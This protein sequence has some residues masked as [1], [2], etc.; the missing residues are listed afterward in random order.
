VIDE[1][2]E[3]LRLRRQ[4]IE[5]V[6]LRTIAIAIGVVAVASIVAA[7][8]PGSETSDGTQVVESTRAGSGAYAID[9]ACS[10]G[11]LGLV[12]RWPRPRTLA[13]VG[14]AF[15]ATCVVAFIASFSAPQRG[16]HE[17]YTTVYHH[18]A[19]RVADDL[20]AGVLVAWLV[21]PIVAFAYGTICL[22]IDDHV[23]R[24]LPPA[25]EFPVARVHDHGNSSKSATARR[26]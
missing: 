2:Y 26:P 5:R 23:R 8:L 24:R 3:Q 18:L 12:W 14:L 4:Q 21:V 20:T 11:L 9:A 22:A 7:M 17:R 10:L 25:P 6:A 13:L 1:R 16:D 15:W 19:Q